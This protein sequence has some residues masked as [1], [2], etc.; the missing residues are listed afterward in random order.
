MKRIRHKSLPHKLFSFT[1]PQQD[2]LPAVK[3]LLDSVDDNATHWAD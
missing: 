2:F 1:D 3:E